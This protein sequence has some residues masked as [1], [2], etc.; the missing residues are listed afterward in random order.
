MEY[1][2][3]TGSEVFCLG[4]TKSFFSTAEL[5]FKLKPQANDIKISP[6][7]MYGAILPPLDRI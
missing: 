1:K 5:N 6:N 4:F 3:S 7:L 2:V